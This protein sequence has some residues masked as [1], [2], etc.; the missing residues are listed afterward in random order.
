M[1]QAHFQW[2]PKCK[3]E[4]FVETCLWCADLE[5]IYRDQV[6]ELT[7][8]YVDSSP[9]S[10]PAILISQQE[11]PSKDIH[12]PCI[13]EYP[14]NYEEA[15]DWSSLKVKI[16]YSDEEELIQCL[17]RLEI[18]I[19]LLEQSLRAKYG[20]SNQELQELGEAHMYSTMHDA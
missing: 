16:R 18:K 8:T 10:A 6:H 1:K 5:R 17:N 19:R 11:V 20:I 15:D 3:H 12:Y 14:E 13:V 9:R 7:K 4:K 2:I